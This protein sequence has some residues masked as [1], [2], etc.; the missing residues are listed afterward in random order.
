MYTIT[1]GGWYQ[2]TTL[3]LSEIYN[4]F[5]FGNSKIGLDKSKLERMW[6]KMGKMTVTREIDYLE[7]VKVI[8]DSG[9]EI[10]YFEDG[11]YLL[12]K[13]SKDLDMGKKELEMYFDEIINPAISYIFSLGAPIPKILANMEIQH[14]TVVF[15]NKKKIK[16]NEEKYGEVYGEIETD[17]VSVKKTHSYIFINSASSKNIRPLIEMQIFFREFKDQLERY[18]D[19]HREIWED[20]SKYKEK[21]QFLVKKLKI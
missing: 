2:R 15:I 3:H 5:A 1:F 16:I 11:L 21:N 4:F 17:F 6:L 19:I 18:L 14:P 12:E 8:T 13:K 9:I 20:I 7:Y 10:R